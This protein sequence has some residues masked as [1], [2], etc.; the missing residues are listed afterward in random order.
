MLTPLTWVQC[1]L[2]ILIMSDSHNAPGGLDQLGLHHLR[3]LDAVLSAGS[4]TRAADELGLSQ[5]AVSHHLSRMREVMGD[6]LVVRARGG[7]VA[8]PRA[9]AL[10]GPLRRALAELEEAIAPAVAWDPATLS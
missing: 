10:A 2:I 1:M 7:V 9:Q 6:P 4:V 8:T 3:A 5:S